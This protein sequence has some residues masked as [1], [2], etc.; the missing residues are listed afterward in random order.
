MNP[1]VNSLLLTIKVALLV[2][3]VVAVLGGGLCGGGFTVSLISN[4]GGPAQGQIS[5]LLLVWGLSA[6]PIG[7]GALAIRWMLRSIR[8]QQAREQSPHT[9]PPPPP[10]H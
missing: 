6:I 5:F 9:P 3:G 8:R 2:A 10:Q 7:L 4:T 1:T